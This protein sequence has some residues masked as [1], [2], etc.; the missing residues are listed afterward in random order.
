MQGGAPG[1]PG[2]LVFPSAGVVGARMERSEERSSPRQI[3]LGLCDSRLHRE[4][5]H[6]VRYDI[7][8]LIKLPQRFGEATKEDIGKRVLGEYV[9]VARVKPLGF[10]EVGLRSG[11]TGLA[12]A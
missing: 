3:A 1:S 5:I 9:N 8:N 10:V 4:R 11:P 2:K 6:V 12:S 7:E